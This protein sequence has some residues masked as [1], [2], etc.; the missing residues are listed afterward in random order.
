M[1]EAITPHEMMHMHDACMYKLTDE[2]FIY[3]H[4]TWTITMLAQ[5]YPTDAQVCSYKDW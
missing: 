1:R 5:N 3:L 2:N 4:S